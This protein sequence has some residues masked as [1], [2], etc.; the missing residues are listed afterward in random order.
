MP[1]EP[2]TPG[3]WD[4]LVDTATSEQEIVHVKQDD[5]SDFYDT[6]CDVGR[7][8]VTVD[9]ANARLIAAAPEMAELLDA[10]LGDMPL[11][12]DYIA[13]VRALLSRIRGEA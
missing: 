10:L 5:L 6:V 11:G 8:D 3:P 7:A 1:S 9:V 13:H 12:P 4:I 2:W